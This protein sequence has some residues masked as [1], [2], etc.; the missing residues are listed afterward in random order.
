MKIHN[1]TDVATS[2]LE[3]HRLLQQT[4]VVGPFTIKPGEHCEVPEEKINAQALAPLVQMAALAVGVLPGRYVA[5]KRKLAEEA[6]I[7][8]ALAAPAA[9]SNVGPLS[10]DAEMREHSDTSPPTATMPSP[11][12]DT[13]PL[14]KK[15]RR[16]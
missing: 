12:D 6:A 13:R 14:H 2:E 9:P 3:A 8:A 5:A 15:P 7:A 1:L 4:F 11:A 16:K 10:G